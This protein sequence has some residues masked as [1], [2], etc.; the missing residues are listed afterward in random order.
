M[1]SDRAGPTGLSRVQMVMRQ[2]A[3]T[4]TSLGD[5]SWSLFPTNPSQVGTSRSATS[6][7]SVIYPRSSGGLHVRPTSE[8]SNDNLANILAMAETVREVLPYIPDD[9]I[10]QVYFHFNVY[11]FL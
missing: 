2:F 3:A 5:V 6:P 8:S 4:Q 7:G 9:I 1:D 11:H 10:F